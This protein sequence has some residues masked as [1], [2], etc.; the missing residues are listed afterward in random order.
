MKS[1]TQLRLT[2]LTACI[3]GALASSASAEVVN[4]TDNFESPTL[5]PFWSIV[6]T[7]GATATYP[8]TDQ[9]N[10]PTHSLKL[11]TLSNGLAKEIQ[12]LHTFTMPV[13]G[14]ISLYIFDSFADQASGEYLDFYAV[15]SDASA[16]KLFT[17]DF[18][19]GPAN[20]G[21][22]YYDTLAT[23]SVSSA[24][25]RTVGWHKFFIDL[26]PTVTTLEIDDIPVF[27][28]PGG[29]GFTQMVFDMHAPGFRPG[30]STYL[31]DAQVNVV[32]EPSTLAMLFCGALI[33][34]RRRRTRS[35]R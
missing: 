12:L 15:R 32:P 4:F 7:N 33:A 16:V 30:G 24:I 34:V 19:L 21:H 11:T 10:S 1:Q 6:T 9:A 35:L 18:D 14:S 26:Q 13:Y 25:D 29:A 3:V 20:G 5:N 31:D 8:S 23:G 22:Y 2:I 27:S 28:G 17:N